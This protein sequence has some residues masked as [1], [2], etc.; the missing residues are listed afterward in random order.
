MKTI[1]KFL[2]AASTYT[3]DF[4]KDSNEFPKA[5]RNFMKESTKNCQPLQLL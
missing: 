3:N 4:L 2:K 1:K 5:A